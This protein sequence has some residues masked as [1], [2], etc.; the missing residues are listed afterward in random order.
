M[1]MHE[2]TQTYTGNRSRVG[3][4]LNMRRAIANL[5]KP[6]ENFASIFAKV[7]VVYGDEAILAGQVY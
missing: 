4:N 7:K 3:Q 1:A 2:N 5:A 6:K